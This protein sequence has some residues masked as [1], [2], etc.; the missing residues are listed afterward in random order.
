MKTINTLAQVVGYLVVALW[1]MG[2]FTPLNFS[3][4]LVGPDVPGVIAYSCEAGDSF[5]TRRK[6]LCSREEW[7]SQQ[8]PRED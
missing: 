2:A 3:L 8:R 4:R 6:Y 1:L 7:A 5:W